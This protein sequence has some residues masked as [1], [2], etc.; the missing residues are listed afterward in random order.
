MYESVKLAAQA[1]GGSNPPPWTLRQAQ[2]ELTMLTMKLKETWFVYLLLCDKKTFYVGITNNIEN[3]L[4]QHNNKKSK[5]TKKFLNIQLVY[6]EEY[7][8]KNES[9][10]REKQLKGWSHAKKQM[11]VDGIIKDPHSTELDEVSGV[12]G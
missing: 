1:S 10:L 7:K 2:C 6:C 5:H 8:T 9:I 11:L 4:T 12:L 3:R